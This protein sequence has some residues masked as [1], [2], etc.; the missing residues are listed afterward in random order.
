MAKQ[1][2]TTP[3]DQPAVPVKK[4]RYSPQMTAVHKIDRI[5]GDLSAVEQMYVYQHLK[6]T[7]E[8]PLMNQGLLPQDS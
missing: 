6:L 7:Y 1:S 2:V 4:K 8:P 3:F 5:L